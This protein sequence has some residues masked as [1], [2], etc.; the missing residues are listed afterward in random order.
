MKE[1]KHLTVAL[2]K[3]V[4]SPVV[5]EQTPSFQKG[6]GKILKKNQVEKKLRWMIECLTPEKKTI[7]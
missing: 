3:V 7:T 6:A 1:V 4:K 2:Q 5:K